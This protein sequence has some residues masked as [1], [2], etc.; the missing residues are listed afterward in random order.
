MAVVAT[1]LISKARLQLQTGVDGQSNP[2]YRNKT[3]S[4]VKTD[5]LDQDIYDVAVALAGLSTD[6]LNSLTRVDENDLANQA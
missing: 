2:I 5:A 3:Y 4:R 1:P 6:T